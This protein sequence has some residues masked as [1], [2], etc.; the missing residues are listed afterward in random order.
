MDNRFS[1]PGL[2]ASLEG[3]TRECALLDGLVGA[4]RQGESRS[5]A[6]SATVVAVIV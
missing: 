5:L 4:I 3:R 6:S 2:Q 1:G